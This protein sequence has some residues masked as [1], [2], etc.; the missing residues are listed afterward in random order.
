MFKQTLLSK[1][2]RNREIIDYAPT[3]NRRN[4]NSKWYSPLSLLKWFLLVGLLAGCAFYVIPLNATTYN[5]YSTLDDVSSGQL[6]FESSETIKTNL[7]ET[8]LYQSAILLNSAASFDINGIIA[9]VTVTQS[10][11]N[12]GDEIANGL[13]TF[14]LP[15]NSAVNY[16]KIQVGNREIEGKIL[17]KNEA[18]KLFNKA[19]ASGKKASLVEQHRPNL[20]TNKIANIAPNEQITVTI[21]YVQH[22]DYTDGEFSLRFPMSITPR[23]QPN[24][25]PYSNNNSE[26]ENTDNFSSTATHLLNEDLS[27]SELSQFTQP[28]KNKISLRVNLNAGI[29]LA[30]IDSPSHT[31]NLNNNE[32]NGEP[33]KISVGNVQVPM[34]KD[35]VLQWRP[36]ASIAP[37]LSLYNQTLDGEEYT[38]A[39]LLPPIHSTIDDNEQPSTTFARDITF[40]IDTSGSMQGDSIKQAKQSLHFALSTLTEKDS[41][42]IIAF[43]SLSTNL[44][45]QTKMATSKNVAKALTFI[46]QLSADGG[47]EMYQPLSNALNM[48]KT[49]LQNE[50]AIKQI[51]FITDGAVSN[52]LALFK[53][54]TNTTDLPRLFTVGIGSA[55][56]GFFMRKAAQFGQG[57]YTFIGNIDEV[58]DKMAMLL[59]KISRPSLTN[60]NVQF[61]PLHLGNIEQYPNKIPDL[62]SNEPLIIAF[63]TTDKPSSIQLFGDLANKGWQ[64]EVELNAAKTVDNNSGI[65][66]I[67]ARAKIEDLLDGLVIGKPL[68]EVKSD[69]IT[70]SL[71][72]Q[73]MSPYTS[74][75]AVEKEI[76]SADDKDK[77]KKE[78]LAQKEKQASKKL[79]SQNSLHAAVFP[80][81]AVG[82]KLQ[83]LLGLILLTLSLI[84]L[85]KLKKKNHENFL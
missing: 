23:Y 48:Q 6:L 4:R 72:H 19:K 60:I 76:L 49:P 51:L 52:E 8:R 14:P 40:I 39:M 47:T 45:Q 85:S 5:N 71:K 24:S 3:Y 59:E 82:W 27:I 46:N 53:L 28:N 62:Y 74:F 25:L 13:Y 15:E 77:R 7:K 1:A 57:S 75:I 58:E 78:L 68:E 64:Q 9:S 67:W 29:Q 35:F 73:V 16:L 43:E 56:N 80:K 31:L 2:R 50:N 10:F 41:F 44:F 34:D 54:I 63:K 66:S 30:S 36:K 84:W 18:K 21:K 79:A 22:L 70:T 17:E 61:H 26:T 81:T 65:S 37:Q 55:P 12:T 69:V 83:F 20:F 38:L 42:N 33:L 11:L 32:L